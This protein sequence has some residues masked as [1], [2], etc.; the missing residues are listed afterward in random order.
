MQCPKCNYQMIT[1][2]KPLEEPTGYI[3]T[4]CRCA[5]GT[6]EIAGLELRNQDLQAQLKTQN[7]LA[8][9]YKERWLEMQELYKARD[10][11]IAELEEAL[12]II[13]RNIKAGAV[14]TYWIA[15]YIDEQ[16]Q[17]KAKTGEGN[18]N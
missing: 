9:R 15:E 4:K 12:E 3:C 1:C 5:I 17:P 11:R 14:T 7:E 13:R 8:A 18:G 6:D 16:L 2:Q 10:G